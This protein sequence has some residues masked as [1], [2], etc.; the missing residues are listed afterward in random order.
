MESMRTTVLSE[1]APGHAAEV[2][3]LDDALPAADRRRLMELGFFPGTTVRAELASPLGD[4]VAY[5]VRGMTVALR[6]SQ[7][8]HIRVRE[9]AET[10]P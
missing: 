2:L 3:A 6:R 4:P 8:A 9:L 1:I 10:S 7:S 5:S